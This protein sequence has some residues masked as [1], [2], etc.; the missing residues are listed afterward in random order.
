M[1]NNTMNTNHTNTALEPNAI[2]LSL[3]TDPLEQDGKDQFIRLCV[4]DGAAVY[5][6]RQDCKS[7]ARKL[8]DIAKQL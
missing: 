5:L 3:V 2:S 8:D 4:K 1:Q 6:T 7:L